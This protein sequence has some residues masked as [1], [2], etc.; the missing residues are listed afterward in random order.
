MLT[1]R[2]FRLVFVMIAVFCHLFCRFPNK[3][4]YPDLYQE[5]VRNCRREGQPGPYVVLC[6]QHFAI[7]VLDRTGQIVRLRD[8]AVPTVFDFPKHFQVIMY[9]I[10]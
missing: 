9:L 3:D 7:D 8:G 10:S 1:Y 5:W 2:L 6:S 4:K